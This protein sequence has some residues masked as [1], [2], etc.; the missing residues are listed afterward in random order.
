MG[1]KMPPI[2]YMIIEGVKCPDYWVYMGDD[3][4]GNHICKNQYNIPVA[5]ASSSMCYSDTQNKIMKFKNAN[6]QQCVSD[7]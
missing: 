5:N 7:R 4:S 2:D 1:K 6:M 3:K